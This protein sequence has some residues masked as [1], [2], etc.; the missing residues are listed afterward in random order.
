MSVSW[1]AARDERRVFWVAVLALCAIAVAIAIRRLSILAGPPSIAESDAA[2]LDAFFAAKP[3]VIGSHALSGLV[4]ALLIP[5]QFSAGIRRRHPCVH[6]WLGRFLL[7]VGILVGGSAYGMMVAPVGGWLETSATSIYGTAFLAALVT[8]WW[9]IRRGD[10]TRHREWML[11]A[12][13][14]VLGIATTRPVMAIFFA[15]STMTTLRPSQFFGMAMWIGFTSTVLAAEWY[16][17]STRQK[18]GMGVSAAVRLGA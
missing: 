8:A 10:V 17:R 2:A 13:G 7:L 15:T 1:S 5:V 12:I 9:H 6:R 18:A 3:E 11:R 4:L 14:I 16:I